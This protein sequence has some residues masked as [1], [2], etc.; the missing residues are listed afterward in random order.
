MQNAIQ[1]IVNL[2][3]AN[4]TVVSRYLQSPEIS[5]LAQ[6]N[7]SR[8]AALMQETLGKAAQTKAFAD[9]SQALIENWVHF[10]QEYT[11]TVDN[12]MMHAEQT[13]SRQLRD[14]D[15]AGQAA[16]SRQQA[17]QA[18]QGEQ[19]AQGGQRLARAR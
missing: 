5:R 8:I 10:M 17:D 4:I 12:F 9:C 19:A 14:A 13:A 15:Q 18:D 1:P 6:E 16:Q 7:A 2:T 11:H 3:N